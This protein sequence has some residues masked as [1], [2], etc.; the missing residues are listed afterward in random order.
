MLSNLA[1]EAFLILRDAFFDNNGVPI[2]YL[3][4]DKKNTQD[5]PFD[6]Y[7]AQILSGKLTDAI[8]IKAPGP[9]ISPDLVLLRPDACQ[10]VSKNVLASDLTKIVAI[11]VKK[12]ERDENGRI[13]RASGIDF[14]TTPPCGTVRVYDLNDSPIAIRGFYLFVCQEQN[15]NGTYFLST[16]ALCDGNILNE[17][18]DLYLK[19]TSQREKEVGLGTYGNGANRIRPMLIFSNP[20]GF[21]K[22]DYNCTL[23]GQ[24]DLKTDKRIKMIYRLFRTVPGGEPKLFFAYRRAEDVPNDWKLEE[25]LDPFPMPAKRNPQTQRRGKFRVPIV[26]HE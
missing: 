25:Y 3:L 19:I 2:T 24:E 15:D 26:S 12:V 21:E 20:L 6:E 14:N 13:A 22:L 5:D 4:R 9:L 16:L 23:I 11:E 8:C 18:Y 1:I 10:G 17:D 7:I